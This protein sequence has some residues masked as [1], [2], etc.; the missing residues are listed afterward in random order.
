[1]D[2]TGATLDRSPVAI[3]TE[4]DDRFSSFIET[5]ACGLGAELHAMIE[6]ATDCPRL[7]SDLSSRIEES[8]LARTEPLAEAQRAFGM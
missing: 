3:L 4:H 5:H 6:A 1:M 7:L 2:L 8:G